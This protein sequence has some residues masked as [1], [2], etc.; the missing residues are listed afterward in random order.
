MRSE[1]M[2]MAPFR[3]KVYLRGRSRLGAGDLE[4][5]SHRLVITEF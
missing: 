3:F 4:Y 1:F 2:A 5:G